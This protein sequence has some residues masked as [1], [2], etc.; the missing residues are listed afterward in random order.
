[1]DQK[2]DSKTEETV[3]SK[4]KSDK[5]ADAEIV[6][7]EDDESAYED[8]NKVTPSSTASASRQK[9]TDPEEEKK[10]PIAARKKAEQ[11]SKQPTKKDKPL[12]GIPR[13]ADLEKAAEIYGVPVKL[14]PLLVETKSRP[15]HLMMQPTLHERISKLIPKVGNK[16]GSFNDFVHQILERYADEHAPLSEDE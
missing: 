10:P 5:G 14:N 1:L 16:K 4:A 2:K 8:N 13:R 15:V 7:T 12:L 6:K 11:K 9:K 3:L